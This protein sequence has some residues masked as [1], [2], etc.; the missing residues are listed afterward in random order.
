MSKRRKLFA[1]RVQCGE[2]DVRVYAKDPGTAAHKALRKHAPGRLR[3]VVVVS[4]KGTTHCVYT[5]AV[6]RR[7]GMLGA[8]I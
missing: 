3:H 2:M 1:Y 4:G 5:R 8:T 7:L 6:L